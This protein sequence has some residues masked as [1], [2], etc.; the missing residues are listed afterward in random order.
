MKKHLWILN[1]Y[2]QEPG[3]PGGIRH[4]ALARHLPVRG[5][6]AH[7]IAA[8]TEHNTGRQRL[9]F[10]E[11]RRLE[12]FEGVPFL[13]L[14]TP[15]YAG[16]GIRRIANM[17]VY[18]ALAL[19]APFLGRIPAP[20]A[21]IGSSV[22]PLA[23][24]AGA[25]LARR[26]G[27]PFVFEIRDLWPQSLVDL[28]Y[29]SETCAPTKAMRALEKSL[30]GRAQRIIVLMPK[31]V[32]YI[33]AL[34]VPAEKISWIPNGFDRTDCPRPTRPANHREFVLMYFGGHGNANMLDMLFDALILVKDRQLARPLKVRLIG[35]GP[36]KPALMERAHRDRLDFVQFEDAV[37]RNRI[38]TVSAEADGF[39]VCLADLPL[40]R[41]GISLNKLF[42]Y[43]AAGRPVILAGNPANN[44]VAEAR[45]GITVKPEPL[46]VADAIEDLVAM[47][48]ERRY[49]WGE[50]ARRHVEDLYTYDNLAR[51]LGEILDDVV[52]GGASVG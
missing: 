22:H 25:V 32:D 46:T 10:P 28:G 35:N 18:T 49:R 48:L 29:L 19:A 44:P 20:D 33:Q 17:L 34:G 9:S 45:A 11:F 43:L 5:W 6:H 41:F 42:D 39:I 8:G 38:P 14:W 3:G 12:V 2:A 52:A 23:A 36:L 47:P 37:P 1:H 16:N 51:Q 30:C 50:N 7:I 31:A 13:W 27:V 4:F 24:W 26:Y 40:Y 21:I 15:T